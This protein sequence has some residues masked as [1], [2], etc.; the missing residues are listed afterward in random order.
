MPLDSL[1]QDK[2]I[3]FKKAF[4]HFLVF[5]IKLFVDAFRDLLFSPISLA[6]FIIDSFTKPAVNESLSFK[7]MHLGR[8]SDR[9]I[10][11]FDEHTSSDHF[12]IDETVKDVETILSKEIKKFKDDIN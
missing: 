12:T 10:N 9:V 7:I 4:R 2:P 3:P 1:P 8:H 6:A 5:Q 11:L